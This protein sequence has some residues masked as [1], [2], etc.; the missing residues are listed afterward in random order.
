MPELVK[1]LFSKDLTISFGEYKNEFEELRISAN[2]QRCRRGAAALLVLN[3]VLILVDLFVYK[4]M[5]ANTPAYLYLYYSHIIMVILTLIWFFLS[6]IAIKYTRTAKMIMCHILLNIIM[7]WCVFMA[8]NNL[9]INGQ[10]T[11]YIICALAI[12]AYIYLTPKEGFVTLITSMVVFI[13]L[14]AYHTESRR[15]LYSH[16]VNTGIVVFF[17]IMISNINYNSFAKDFIN[18][19]DIIKGKKELEETNGK[20]MEYEKLRT[21]F[22]AN[23]SHELRTP[24]NVIYSAQQMLETTSNYNNKNDEKTRKYLRMMKQNSYRLIRLINNLIDITKIDSSNFDVTLK[25]ADIIKIVEDITM[26]VA[27]Y[28]ESKGITLVFDTEVEE[29]NIACDEDVVERIVLNLLSNAIKFTERGGQISVNIYVEKGLVNIAVKDTGIGIS[30]RMKALIFDRFIQVDKSTRR[31]REGSGI[32]LALVR[33]LLDVHGG[34]I[35]VHS[36]IGQGSEFVVTL[37]DYIIEDEVAATHSCELQNSNIEMINIEFSD[38]Y[39]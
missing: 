34:D 27:E 6:G 32:G 23:I 17:S 29:K 14:L 12:D 11:A 21:D 8:V 7:Y 1:L 26:S 22:F 36:T 19:K 35:T 33:S 28:M 2:I 38:I 5:R 31:R 37:P 4:D 3:L 10:I 25:N 18:K 20:L 13:L 16:I 30:E 39:E 9:R 15:L 24:L